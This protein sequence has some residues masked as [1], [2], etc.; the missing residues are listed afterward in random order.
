[1]RRILA[2]AFLLA[3]AVRPAAAEDENDTLRGLKFQTGKITL[4]RG[5]AT[6]SLSQNFVYLDPADTETFLTKV[7]DN[8][9]GTGADTL[10]MLLP[11]DADA[12][13][14]NGWAVVIDY[15]AGGYV[16]DSDANT[17][18]YN[19]LL[20]SMQESTEEANKER[21]KSGFAAIT[22][23]GWAKPPTYDAAA[24]K[25]YWAKQLRFEG[26]KSD[27]LNYN[28]RVLGR[29]GVLTLNAVAG[30]DQLA[31]IDRHVPEI[32]GMVSFN[33]GNTYAEYDPSIDKAAAYGIA[34]LIAGGVLAKV[35]FFK[36][37]LIGILAF[38]KALVVG[39]LAV[40]GV[41][42]KLAK[43]LFGKSTPPTV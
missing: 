24:H 37:L 13:G 15:D 35:G 12:L 10:G 1:M 28:I 16:S 33:Q 20:K 21:A 11:K 3:L 27:T 30:I 42:A 22:L 17:I 31:M 38:K 32:L 39:V 5:I 23:V 29:R 19:Q 4:A 6:L 7:W 43:R 8:P 34:G 2:F 26:N 18:D 40:F 9:P 14:A 41:V 25:L 36:A